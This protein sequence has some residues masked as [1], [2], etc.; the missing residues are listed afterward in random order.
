[1]SAAAQASAPFDWE[2]L[3]GMLDEALQTQ[4]EKLGK[5]NIIVAGRTGTGKSTLV[6]AVFGEDFAETA[7]G[8]PVTQHATWYELERHPLRILDTKGLETA[9]YAQTW[10]ALKAEIIKG[11]RSADSKDHI[12]I[13]WVCVQEPATRFEPAE[14]DLVQALK[15][16][17]IPAIVVVTK[18]GLFPDFAAAVRKLA[19]TADAVVPV[20]A[21]GMPNFPATF[22]LED[23]ARATFRLL[24]EAAGNAFV[25][26]Q[27]VDFGMKAAVARKIIASAATAAAGA[28]AAPL[29]FS[30][31]IA[32]APIQI[33]MIVSI[34][35]RF[36]IDG[37]TK[38]LLS[39]AASLVG[40]VAATA[41]GRLIVGQLLKLVPGGGLVNAAV[42]A[43]LTTGLGEAYL[44]FLLAFHRERGRLPSVDEITSGFAAFWK[45]W[46]EKGDVPAP[47][48]PC[49]LDA[50]RT[51]PT[52][53][54]V[55]VPCAACSTG[56]RLPLGRSGFV[57]CPECSTRAHYSL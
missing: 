11:R 51:P 16:E 15:D 37:T 46:G 33:G 47:L 48:A 52:V 24:P 18:H 35:L 31:A 29:P 10:A 34:S 9:D 7:I 53:E 39:L 45:A 6:N 57:V 30:D 43:A 25:A 38:S 41:V 13:G 12:H 44:A 4:R 32:I 22:G 21:L 55:T 3:S 19:P 26:A 8:R 23:L 20:R 28:A 42:A 17:G 54:R 36:G 56:L 14:Q 50:P 27:S 40:C 2:R 1:M 5:I 49:G